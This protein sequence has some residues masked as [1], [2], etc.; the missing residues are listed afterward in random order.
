MLFQSSPAHRDGC[1]GPCANLPGGSQRRFNPHPPTG[2]GAASPRR[3][4]CSRTRSF[5]PHPPTG[6]GAA[7]AQHHR[8]IIRGSF[9]PHPPTGTGAARVRLNCRR[10]SNVFQSSP[11]HRDGCCFPGPTVQGRTTEVSILTRP[12]GRVLLAV[13][14]DGGQLHQGFNP[15]PPTG[16]GAASGVSHLSPPQR[17]VSIL[18]RPQGRVLLGPLSPLS[19][20]L[21]GFNPHPPTG[22]GAAMI[23][24]L[25]W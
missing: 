19:L 21:S 14:P 25:C 22:T 10:P 20:P 11:A 13:R 18:T 9:N 4:W 12:Q 5:N 7:S 2:T 23:P 16:T 24:P 15:H 1:C 6:T 17:A 8:A 3:W